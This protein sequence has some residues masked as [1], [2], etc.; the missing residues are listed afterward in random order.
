MS[1]LSKRSRGWITVLNN[2]TE[3][4]YNSILRFAQLHTEKYVFGK[5]VGTKE[6][7][8]HIQGYIYFKQPKIGKKIKELLNNERIKIIKANG[9]PTQNYEYCSKDGDFTAGG[10]DDIN[11]LK[12]PT[13]GV[14][15]ITRNYMKIGDK[16][17]PTSTED[18][19]LMSAI[20]KLGTRTYDDDD[21][22][23]KYDENE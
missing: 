12:Q 6:G 10:F 14:D 22:Y 19:D 18:E 3:D 4:E 1:E 8:P 20:Q 23:Y 17:H 13:R 11:K 15:N 21:D 9:N 5:E 16:W 7:T 2:Y